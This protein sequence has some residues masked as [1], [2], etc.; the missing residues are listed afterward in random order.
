MS[1][2]IFINVRTQQPE[3]TIYNIQT[4]CLNTPNYAKL[5]LTSFRQTKYYM[6][7]QPDAPKTTIFI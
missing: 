7:Q 5:L 4:D 6:N 2:N 3:Y 1:Q